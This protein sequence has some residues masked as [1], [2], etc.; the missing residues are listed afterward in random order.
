M[1]TLGYVAIEGPIGVGKTTLATRLAESLGAELLLEA[2]EENPFLKSFYD[3]PSAYAFQAQL[4]FLL[5]RARQI[6]GLGQ[7]D[8]FNGCRVTDFM[9]EKDPLFAHLNLSGP[10][11][12]LYDDVYQRLSWEAPKPDKVIYLYAPV[13]T[14]VK[15]VQKRARWAEQ[16][17]E[18]DY[19]VQVADSYAEYFQHYC[20]APL[21]TVNAVQRDLVDCDADYQA[22]LDALN[23]PAPRVDL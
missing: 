3:D 5:Q 4:F 9:F 11:L 20:E 17:L 23:D 19:L 7:R 14:L 13:D 6:E 8:L 22:L 1:N 21:V 10:E 16:A 12:A 15:R 2:P 18:P